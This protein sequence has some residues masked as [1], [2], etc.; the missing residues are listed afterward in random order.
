MEED[1]RVLVNEK[2]DMSQQDVLVARKGNSILDS[3]KREV[4]SRLREVIV[5]LRSCEA[6]SG[7]LCPGVSS[8][9]H[10]ALEVSPE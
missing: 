4:A 2:L 10:G 9:R 7:I 8:T 3:I 1:F 6:S 5:P